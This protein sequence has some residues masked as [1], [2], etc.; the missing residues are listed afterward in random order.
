MTDGKIT[1]KTK[2]C[3]LIGDPVS[4]SL[5]PEIHNTAFNALSLDFVYLAFKVANLKD[6]VSGLRALGN[7]KGASVTI[8][9]KVEILKYL[10]EVDDVAKNI[11]SV[12]TIVKEEDK[13][14][15]YNSDGSGALKALISFDVNLDSK[16]IVMLGS[17]GAARAIAFTLAMKTKPESLTV[18]G[19][20]EDE[21]K[22][23]VDDLNGKTRVGASGILLNS[24]SLKKS[25]EE[26]NV[27]IHCTPSG[28]YPKVD[29]TLIPKELLNP[30]IA[31]FDIVYNPLKTRLLTEAEKRGCKIIF[32]V[33]MFVNQAVIQF[34]LWTEKEAPVEIMRNVV[35]EKL[36]A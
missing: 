25:L 8:P 6:A 22:R 4:H 33:E 10:D 3:C 16:N 24:H 1:A 11:G 2:M 18:M 30:G 29:E 7:F 17:G 23:L 12:N 31:V 19:I 26:C 20:I 35:M 28:M 36:I 32:G 9:H 15:G 14:I 34:Q 27:L 5:S 13:L 21:I